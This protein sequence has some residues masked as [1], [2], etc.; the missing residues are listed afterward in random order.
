[1]IDPMSPAYF[2]TSSIP[3]GYVPAYEYC[4]SNGLT[5]HLKCF[6]FDFPDI[7]RF[8]DLIY[9]VLVLFHYDFMIINVLGIKK[10]QRTNLGSAGFARKIKIDGEGIED[11]ANLK[12]GVVKIQR[13]IISQIYSTLI[14]SMPRRF[15]CVT[16][17]QGYMINKNDDDKLK[18]C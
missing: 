7:L 2:I 13:T 10:V 3:M 6:Y 14:S 15:Q 5:E 12:V 4:S 1:M 8:R 16:D 17:K 11:L 18:M 9:T